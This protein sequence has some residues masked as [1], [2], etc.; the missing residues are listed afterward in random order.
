MKI[1]QK[2]A[3][4]LVKI[5]FA[6]DAKGPVQCVMGVFQIYDGAFEQQNNKRLLTHTDD[7]GRC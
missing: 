6:L 1:L 5:I 3:L 2:S 7:T 4:N